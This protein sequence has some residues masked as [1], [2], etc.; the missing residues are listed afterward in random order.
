[1]P[2]PLFQAVNWQKIAA[3]STRAE[4]P[5]HN[6]RS[7]WADFIQKGYFDWLLVHVAAA[8][9]ELEI[10]PEDIASVSSAIIGLKDQAVTA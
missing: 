8:T 10:E 6:R 7:I 3:S 1:M 2:R 5:I 9:E 4:S